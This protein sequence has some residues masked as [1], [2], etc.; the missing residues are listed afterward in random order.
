VNIQFRSKKQAGSLALQLMC[1]KGDLE[2]ENER[3]RADEADIYAEN[4]ALWF[5]QHNLEAELGRTAI[6]LSRMTERAE[7][8]EA[9]LSLLRGE[10]TVSYMCGYEDGKKGDSDA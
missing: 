6:S 10:H 4:D 1:E 9:E 5:V 7:E 3:L 8:A 2:K